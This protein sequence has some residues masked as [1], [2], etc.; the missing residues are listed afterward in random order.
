MRQCSECGG[1]TAL[2]SQTFCD[3]CLD[4]MEHER[5]PS[6]L[7]PWPVAILGL[8]VVLVGAADDWDD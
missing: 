5:T 2:L 8:E 6:N 1:P 3:Y 4:E 7:T